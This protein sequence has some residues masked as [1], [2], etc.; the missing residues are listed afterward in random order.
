MLLTFLS[1]TLSFPGLSGTTN[2]AE[3]QCASASVQRR[4]VQ[5]DSFPREAKT[6]GALSV[7]YTTQRSKRRHALIRRKN[8]VSRHPYSDYT[9]TR[10]APRPAHARDKEAILFC[11]TDEHFPEGVLPKVMPNGLPGEYI[12]LRPFTLDSVSPAPN[13]P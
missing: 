11:V 13:P 5:S 8:C 10:S 4:P 1:H 9:H 7:T 2:S 3:L 12:L 6:T